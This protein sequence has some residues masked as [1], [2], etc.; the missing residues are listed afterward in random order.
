ML[1][2]CT[3]Q[4]GPIEASSDDRRATPFPTVFPLPLFPS[5]SHLLSFPLPSQVAVLFKSHADLLEEFTYFLPDAQ[6]AKESYNRARGGG[7]AYSRGGTGGRGRGS[8]ASP[9]DMRSQQHKR[10]AAKK[11]EEGF[12]AGCECVKG[13]GE[14]AAV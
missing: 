1:L 10:K 11:A 4:A 2:G 14:G 6:A 8:A 3:R 13:R 7:A 9:P 5:P 12:R